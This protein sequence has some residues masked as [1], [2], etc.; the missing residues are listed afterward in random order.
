LTGDYL[1][2]ANVDTAPISL[3]PLFAIYLPAR[4]SDLNGQTELH[5]LIKGPLKN[6]SAINGQ[7][8]IPTLSLFYRQDLQLA[9]TQPIQLDYKN[10]VLTLQRT[11]L[12]GTGTNLQ[13]EGSLPVVGTGPI[14]LSA[15]GDINLHLLQTIDSD[16]TS[17]GE[18]ELNIR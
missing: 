1:A 13:L 16:F 7:I 9:N 11:G 2:E 18:L 3:A 10:G 6:P 4:V 14:S 17:S 15:A 8:T 12:R 5:A